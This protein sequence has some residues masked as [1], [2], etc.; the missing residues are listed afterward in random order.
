[1]AKLLS[2]YFVAATLFFITLGFITILVK[3]KRPLR[4]LLIIFLVAVIP[5]IVIYYFSTKISALPET[6]V[7]KLMGLSVKQAEP[8]AKAFDL[9]T[10]VVQKVYEKD[11]PED[12]IIS[13]RPEAGRMVKIGR[14]IDLIVSIGKRRVYMP[15]LV[16][17]DLSQVEVVVKE[18]GLI[19][20]KI[21]KVGSREF[22]TNTVMSQ[23][24][25]AGEEILVGSH[26][27][28][29]ICINPE[30]EEATLEAESENEEEENE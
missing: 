3:I 1:M 13:Q 5:L 24:P 9:K 27:D 30:E 21:R 8:V 28:I 22:P 16:G 18:A 11:I 4:F 17:R 2:F 26:V 19:L 29:T 20:G 7:P 25:T 15:S 23:Y 14:T 12:Q 10:K 6:K